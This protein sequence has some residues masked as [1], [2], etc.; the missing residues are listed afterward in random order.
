MTPADRRIHRN[1]LGAGAVRTP[2]EHRLVR[3]AKVR[4][5]SALGAGACLRRARPS[6]AG[7]GR[8][9]NLVVRI[10]PH[11]AVP[12]CQIPRR[13]QLR[14]ARGHTVKRNFLARLQKRHSRKLGTG[15]MIGTCGSSRHVAGC[16]TPRKNLRSGTPR[17]IRSLVEF[18]VWR[19]PPR[20]RDHHDLGQSHR[21][22]ADARRIFVVGR[23]AGTRAGSV[24][25]LSGRVASLGCRI[26]PERRPEGLSGFFFRI[27]FLGCFSRSH[28]RRKNHSCPDWTRDRSFQ[29]TPRAVF[30]PVRRRTNRTPVNPRLAGISYT[31]AGIFRIRISGFL[32]FS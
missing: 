8:I 30:R 11:E 22:R 2:R 21:D 19:P 13:R 3:Y 24:G 25:G 18:G 23:G 16:G 17:R 29:S 26:E 15:V 6:Y 14:M 12:S 31:I 28:A 32:L 4:I 10:R 1:G 5:E 9:R 7:D 20:D 27:Y